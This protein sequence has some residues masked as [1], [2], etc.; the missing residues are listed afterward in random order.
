MCLVKKPKVVSAPVTSTEKEAAILRNPYL[1]G[2]APIIK[3]RQGGVKALTI[4]RQTGGVQTPGL[5]TLPTI[6]LTPTTGGNTGGS[7][8]GNS[9]SDTLT[10]GTRT[11]QRDNAL[12]I[13]KALF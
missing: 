10:G 3:A 13:Q 8:G 2:L 1:D 6:P 12:S 7:T 5:P 11:I 4:R 9:G